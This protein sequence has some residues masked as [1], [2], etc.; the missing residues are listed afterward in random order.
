[1]SRPERGALRRWLLSPLAVLALALGAVGLLAQES[2]LADLAGAACITSILVLSWTVF[3]GPSR[4]LSF[5]H[6]FFVGAAGYLAALLQARLQWS[7]WAALALGG[8]AGA[9][10]GLAVA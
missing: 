10:L 1:M 8:V 6:A 9:G 4:E 2:F 5:G 3:C 7:P